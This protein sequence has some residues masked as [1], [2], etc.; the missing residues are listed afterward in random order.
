MTVKQFE[1]EMKVRREIFYNEASTF[2]NYGLIPVEYNKE[3]VFNSYR[4]VRAQG[5]TRPLLVD[6]KYLMT[7]EGV[8]NDSEYGD[9]YK[10]LQVAPERLESMQ[11]HDN[12]LKA[13][14]TQAQFDSLKEAYPD[15]LLV[16]LITKDKVDTNKTKGIKTKTLAVI[17]EKINR[18]MSM[19]VLIAKLSDLSLSTN[20]A[21]KLYEH[22]GSSDAV[23]AAIEKNIYNLCEVKQF[24]FLTVDKVAMS[25]GDNPTN[26]NRITA[27]IMYLLEKDNQSGHTWSNLNELTEQATELLNVNRK[28]VEDVIS[29]MKDNKDYYIEGDRIAYS[30]VRNQEIEVYAHLKRIR[31]NYIQ[32]RVENIEGRLKKV[33]V[34][35]G[36]EFTEEQRG[37][38]LEGS[39]H[40]AIVI[41]GKA[42]GGKTALS[43]GLIKSLDN[44]YYITAALSGAAVRV[45]D[46]RGV[47]AM[48]IHRMLKYTDGGFQH[49]EHEPTSY[50]VIIVDEIS[51]VAVPLFLSVV[52]AVKD[53]A[54][55]II[56]GD[57]G[58]LSGIGYGNTIR[59]L[60]ETKAFPS[61]ELTQVHRQAA[62]SGILEIANKV[63]DGEQLLPYNSSGSFTYG[64]LKD[65]TVLAYNNKDSIPYDVLRIATD[66]KKKIKSPQDLID[67]Q[68]I[69]PNRDRGNLSVKSMNTEL[70]S[71]FND[72]SKEGLKRNGYTFLE[73][74]KVIAQGNSYRMP[75]F[76]SENDYELNKHR[77]DEEEKEQELETLYE[78]DYE[79]EEGDYLLLDEQQEK[80][81]IKRVDV[82]NGS[83]GWIERIVGNVAL[84][85]FVGVDGLVPFDNNAFDKIDMGY[86]ITVHRSQG[87]GIR[88]VV[89]CLDFGGY[90]LLSRQLVYVGLTRATEK[91]VM[92]CETN[93]LH[94]AIAN[95]ESGNRRTFL[96]DI[97]KNDISGKSIVPASVLPVEAS[98]NNECHDGYSPFD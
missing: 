38:I 48:T 88:F 81:K 39:G 9:Y 94:K 49:N 33:E 1:L 41:N 46:L 4:N 27:C 3:L 82:F 35:Q 52:K 89:F 23:L 54:Q 16:D 47:E 36:F 91:C 55:L 8:Y 87:S 59:D 65:M 71:V 56:S 43:S 11:D 53:G 83:M 74:D 17:K 19:S 79:L 15:E 26:K 12:F 76:K 97:I 75:S 45:L 85:K 14:I 68:V 37:A 67:F 69:V 80:E 58:Q 98:M 95:D 32:P 72:T 40:G 62:K 66:Y 63:R 5:N 31:D 64:E 22:F 7:I 96:R 70:Q 73:G 78:S 77:A 86:A 61:Y 20:A 6:N 44:P 34:E 25:R 84:I 92:L 24:G 18:N 60:L 29:D 21:G 13:V 51:M 28:I 10:I 42:G 93:A 2:G 30:F 50:D 90:S 57:S